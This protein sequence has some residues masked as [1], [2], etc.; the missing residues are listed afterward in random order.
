MNSIVY[1][2]LEVNQT[3]FKAT[4]QLFCINVHFIGITSWYVFFME[5]I[6]FKISVGFAILSLAAKTVTY[7]FMGF[8][9]YPCL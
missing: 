1:A 4:S 2:N 9:P 8:L 7:K 5:S 3:F 6:N